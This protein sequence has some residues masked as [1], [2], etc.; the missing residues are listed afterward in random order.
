MV[1]FLVILFSLLFLGGVAVGAGVLYVLYEYGRGLPD[2]RQLADYEPPVTTR[3]YAGDGRLLAEYAVEKRVFVP[4]AAMPQRVVKAFLSAEDKSFYQHGGLDFMGILRAMVVNLR[5]YGTSHKPM[6]ASTITQQVT[7]NFLL[8]NEVSFE[9]KIKE[10]ILSFRIE[11]T[12][13]KDHILE[14]YLNE[15]YLGFGS[16]GVTAAAMNYF[17]KSLDELTIAETA[18]LAALPKA[19]NNYHPLRNPAAARERRDWVIGRLTED[20]HITPAEAAQAQSEPLIVRDRTATEFIKGGDYFAEDVRRLLMERYGEQ[21]LYEGG[22]HVRT[23]LNPEVQKIA[24][25]VLRQGLIDYDRRHGW[26][27]AIGHTQGGTGW[28]RRLGEIRRPPGMPVEWSLAVVLAVAADKAEIG[29]PDGRTGV[30]PF[31]ELAWARAWKPEQTLGPS[32]R[33]V[34]DVLT[35]GNVVAVEPLEARTGVHG[36]RQMPQV[37]GALVSLDPHTGRVLAMAGGFAYERSEF[38]RA[39]QALR[40]P[41]SAFKPFVYLAA[42]DHG[43]T[44]SSVVLDAPF[45]VDQGPGRPKWKPQNYDGNYLGPTTLRVGIE[46]SRNVMT[47]RLAQAVGMPVVATYA[48]RF[49]IVDRLPPGLAMA[50]GAA[51]TTVLR[52][53]GAYAMLVNGGK[54]IRPTLIDRIQDRT[55]RTI[56]RHDDRPCEGC[57]EKTWREQTMP[58]IPDARAQV[59]DPL[60]AYQMV[61]MLQGV[62]QHGTGRRVAEVGKPLAGKTGTSNDSMDTWFVGFSPDLAVGVF[63]GFDE[64]RSL[65]SK[66]TGGSVAA[67]IFRDFMRE[68]L[69]DRPT[70]D[71][72]MPSGVRLVRVHHGN[73]VPTTGGERDVILEAFKPGTVPENRGTV[74]GGEDESPEE[75]VEPDG[76][77]GGNTGTSLPEAGGLY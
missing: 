2:Y 44:P 23:T 73:G 56:Y 40:Q 38:N 69:A 46:K 35:T 8:T 15:I 28:I 43:Y 12:F 10:A 64:P 31:A 25:R 7:K 68:I 16:Y 11:K 30:L 18:F 61:S 1:R 70:A 27:G 6:G 71:F 57:R 29:L 67:P 41:G 24:E 59:T 19:P 5:H 47:V 51:E 54:Q 65:G 66:E 34:G 37:D 63:V 4:L 39:T 60:S 77:G 62:V 55:G 76:E 49:G 52:L 33:T 75:E 26:R 74:L 21:A 48:K 13:S 42:L 50:L 17:N 72:R 53:T 32:V 22:L 58:I 3:I 45:V 14:L 20:G 9:R 36:L